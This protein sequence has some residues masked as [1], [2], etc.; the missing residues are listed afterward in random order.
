MESLVSLIAVRFIPCDLRA[1]I[2]GSYFSTFVQPLLCK[3][4]LLREE[5]EESSPISVEKQVFCPSGNL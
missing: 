3:V 4:I 1:F 2:S 5:S